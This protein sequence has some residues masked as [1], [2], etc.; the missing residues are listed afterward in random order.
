MMLMAAFCMGSDVLTKQM[1]RRS[2]CVLSLNMVALTVGAQTV[3]VACPENVVVG[4]SYTMQLKAKLST[5]YRWILMQPTEDLHIHESDP[6]PVDSE[7]GDTEHVLQT[8]KMQAQSPLA[9]DLVW[10]YARPEQLSK[11][12]LTASCHLVAK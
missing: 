10:L 12:V 5:G 2:L 4:Q 1:W 11:T 7:G 8:W 6:E 9:T 3:Q